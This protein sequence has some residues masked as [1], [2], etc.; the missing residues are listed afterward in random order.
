MRKASVMIM[1]VLML[2]ALVAAP[3]SA[4]D[5]T[6]VEIAAGNENFSTLVAA[7]QA[8]DPSIAEALSSEGE[9]T[10]FA[11]T[12]E[13]FANLLAT[14]GL[15]AEELLAETEILNQVLLYHVVPGE[16]FAADVVGLDGQSAPTLLEGETVQIAVT[17]DGVVLNEIVNVVQTDI[18]A[19]N[20]VIHV[21]D[22]V[23]L[24]QVVIDALGLGADEEM[25]EE[26]EEMMAEFVNIR[27]A[28][29]SP[30]TPAVDVYVDGEVAVE[31]LEFPVVTDFLTL[32][33]GTYNI[34]V[35]PTGTSI[36]DAAIGPADFELPAGAFVTVAAVGSLE[37]D[38][39][40]PA[41]F[42]EGFAELPE[43]TASVTV[44]HAIE[45]A[46][47]VDVLAA[48]A[49]IITELA[50][51][52]SFTTPEGTPNDGAFTLEVP[53]G[54]Y[55][56]AV[57]PSGAT[58]PVVIDLS[59]TTLEAGMYYLVAAIGSLEEPQVQVVA[60]DAETAAGL[61]D[62]LM[63]EEE[64]M[65]EEMME[66]AP[67]IPEIV[68]SSTEADPAEFTILLAA[69]QN[70]DPAIL[71]TLSGEGPFT[72]FAP[73]DAAFAALLETLGMT[74]EDLL[75]ATDVLTNTLL[76]HVIS[77]EFYAEDVIG[78]DGQSAETLLGESVSVAIV[79]GGVVLND[80]VNVI[81]TDIAASNGVIHVI[82]SVLVPQV[83]LDALGM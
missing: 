52:G 31:A 64:M 62:A 33:A 30:D 47:A 76:Y 49:P 7:V 22:E 67:S 37:A 36:D 18:D 40:A 5:Q 79:D 71:E 50:F 34:A 70:A 8:A 82:D 32:P 16:F 44:F 45:D 25:M 46:P 63:G 55:D 61:N 72:V 17:D 23:L 4:Q 42:T 20:G 2:L 54:E 35:A 28:H 3:A 83:V 15:T 9:L 1:A 58:E 43:E 39:L 74:A 12:N 14:L 51:P 77:G 26:E 78:L 27:V 60:I 11:P 65:E 38:T 6:I 75:G 41:V 56:L 10:V 81:Q 69:I 73:T 29:F 21:I 13:A 24:P 53:A 59:G 48:D 68:I 57:V 66:E 19:S 80:G